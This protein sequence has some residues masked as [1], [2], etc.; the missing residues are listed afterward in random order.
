MNILLA[1]DG[2]EYTQRAA[3]YL[4]SNA[5][6]LTQKPILHLLHV[7]PEFPF[8][9]A[10]TKRGIEQYNR[11]ESEHH[12]QGNEQEEDVQGAIVRGGRDGRFDF[13]QGGGMSGRPTWSGGVEHWA[14]KAGV[15]LFLWHKPPAP[16]TPRRGTLFFVHGSSMA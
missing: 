11:E 8:P 9:G 15:R 7:R 13:D 4:A 1:V 6:A 16:G 12:A 5:G 10:T 3:R 2:S 14:D